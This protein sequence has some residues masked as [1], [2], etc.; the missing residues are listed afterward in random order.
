MCHNFLLEVCGEGILLTCFHQFNFFQIKSRVLFH[1]LSEN[2]KIL[3]IS[4][5]KGQVKI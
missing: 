5:T 1:Y 4:H 3:Y 2:A